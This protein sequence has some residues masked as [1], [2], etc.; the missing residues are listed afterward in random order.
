MPKDANRNPNPPSRGAA[1]SET[2]WTD[3]VF[4]AVAIVFVTVGLAWVV[5]GVAMI[6]LY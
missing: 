4:D 3:R 5:S 1:G 6:I 2:T